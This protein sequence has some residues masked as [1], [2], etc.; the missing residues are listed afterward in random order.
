MA[1]HAS[2]STAKL[3]TVTGAAAVIGSGA[4]QR[5]VYRGGVFTDEGVKPEQIEH[6]KSVNLI[7]D[8]V[9][10]TSQEVTLPDGDPTEQWTVVQLRKYAADNSISLGSATTKADIAAAIIA[11]KADSDTSG[12][13]TA[14]GAPGA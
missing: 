2:P 8:H 3:Y 11:A 9:A 1:D 14:G 10:D 4:A 13:G 7:A 12:T 6:L 5:Y